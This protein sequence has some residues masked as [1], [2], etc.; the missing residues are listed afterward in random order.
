MWQQIVGQPSTTFT[1]ADGPH[2]F[3]ADLRT[4]WLELGFGA[5]PRTE[6]EKIDLYGTLAYSVGLDGRTNSIAAK[7]GLKG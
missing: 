6:D 5:D 4:A 2:T 3:Q 7:L 1:S